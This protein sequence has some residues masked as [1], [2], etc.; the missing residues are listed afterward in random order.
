MIAAIYARKSP[1]DQNALAADAKSAARQ[2]ATARAFAEGRGWTVDDAHVY[3]D[4]LISGAEFARRPGLVRLL[5]ALKPRPAFGVLLV[6]DRDRI[7]REQIE[8]SYVLKQLITAGVRVFEVGKGG[9]EITLSSPTD[10]IIM[11]VQDFASEVEREKARS[12]TYDAMAHRAR[13]GRSTG[14]RMFG[15]TSVRTPEG[16]V[17]RAI[18][19]AEAKTVRRIFALAAE[20]HGRKVI[21]A[22]LNESAAPAPRKGERSAGWAPSTVRGVLYNETYRGVAVWNRSRKRDGWGQRRPTRRAAAEHL[23]VDVPALRIVDEALWTAAHARLDAGRALYFAHTGEHGRNGGRPP[24]GTASRY[25]LSGL[26]TCGQ[27]GGSM[28]VHRRDRGRAIYFGCSVRHLRGKA[29]CK[30]ILEVAVADVDAAV[31][32]SVERDLLNVAVLETAMFKAMEQLHQQDGPDTAGQAHRDELARLDAE[33]A[34]LAAAIAAGGDMPAL[35]VAVQERERRRAHLRGAIAERE[36]QQRTARASQGDVID[37][38]RA[39]LTDWQGMLRQAPPADRQALQALLAG[40]LV[41]T[42]AE[43]DGRRFY[44]FEG[45][46]TVSPVLAGIV[47]AGSKGDGPRTRTIPPALRRALHHRDKGCRFPGCGLRFVQG[48]HVRHWAHGGPTTLSNLVLLCRRHHRAVHEEH[49]QV[50]RRPDG[51]WRFRRPDGRV[52]PEVPPPEPIPA[53]PVEALRTRHVAQGLR[54]HARTA[55]AGWLGEPLDVGWA[56]D[57]LHPR[58]IGPTAP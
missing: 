27:C 11:A 22:M 25:L 44:T 37:V 39:A 42:P 21:A 16:H 57:V 6:T 13:A 46:G 38:L 9:Q 19:P 31:L 8:T 20:G 36:R 7:G 3:V 29:V 2:I 24:S 34:R 26:G 33:V 51:E 14:G 54:L 12:R 4:D 43:Q 50:E 17:T 45:K 23:R 28:F 56:I 47:Q 49:V 41:F 48:H 15:Y 30:N 35:V 32:A 52:L 40:R 10:K 5:A 18:V 55:C 58:A 53:D 1:D